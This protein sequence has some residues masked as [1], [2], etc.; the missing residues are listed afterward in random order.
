MKNSTI[1]VAPIG[2]F[3]MLAVSAVGWALVLSVNDGWL[4]S[5]KDNYRRFNL[6]KLKIKV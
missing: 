3:R 4:I 6:I 5:R 2:Q 1:P